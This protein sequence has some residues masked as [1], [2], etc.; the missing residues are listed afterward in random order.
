M[1]KQEGFPVKKMKFIFFKNVSVMLIKK[2]EQQNGEQ[3]Q[4]ELFV[5]GELSL[6]EITTENYKKLRQLAPF[7]QANPKPLFLFKGII[8][9]SVEPFGKDKNHLK[10]WFAN[11]KGQKISANQIF[12]RLTINE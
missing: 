3:T 9:E 5:D 4:E 6:D 12:C 7:G 2:Y 8:P 1:L 11:T 10:V